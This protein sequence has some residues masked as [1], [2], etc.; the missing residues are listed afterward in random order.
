MDRSGRSFAGGTPGARVSVGSPSRV[1]PS[2][3]SVLPR[4]GTCCTCELNFGDSR[5]GRQPAAA[6]S[7]RV[8]MAWMRLAAVALACGWLGM[9]FSG[10]RW[11]R[12][13]RG[14]YEAQPQQGQDRPP[15]SRGG[16]Q[17][18]GGRGVA[19]GKRVRRQK[20]NGRR[21]AHALLRRAR[22]VVHKSVLR[23]SGG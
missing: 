4:K 16:C 23:G 1:G 7:K 11:L 13:A 6:D 21:E 17:R 3:D 2:C 20:G 14:T 18:N 10:G 15:A 12:R 19:R 5:P 9:F 22:G 8:A